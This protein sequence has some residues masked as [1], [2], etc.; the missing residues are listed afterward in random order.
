MMSNTNTAF[1]LLNP[2]G[3]L[4]YKCKHPSDKADVQTSSP[5]TMDKGVTR[6]AHKTMPFNSHPVM[7]DLLQFNIDEVPSQDLICTPP[8]V[9]ITI[10][11]LRD[12]L[13]EFRNGE[14]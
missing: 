11:L 3:P 14:H 9:L 5:L 6:N 1:P 4:A 7:A 8:S 13:V 12:D 10:L 2:G